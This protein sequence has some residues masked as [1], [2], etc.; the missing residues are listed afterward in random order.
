MLGSAQ[1][2][3]LPFI[4]IFIFFSLRTNILTIPFVL[5][6]LLFP[7]IIRYSK[8]PQKTNI[9]ARQTCFC[10]L[11]DWVLPRV[12]AECTP[13]S[14]AIQNPLLPFP[15]LLRRQGLTML[16]PSWTCIIQAGLKLMMQPRQSPML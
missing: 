15:F 4:F 2:P 8:K 10:R 13:R 14:N 7:F 5:L 16:I 9:P 11:C 12:K 6:L 3:L 1:V